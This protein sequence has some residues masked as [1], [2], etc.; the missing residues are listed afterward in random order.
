MR[1]A[2]NTIA[3]EEVA[4]VYSSEHEV[5]DEEA[6]VATTLVPRAGVHWDEASDLEGEVTE[7]QFDMTEGE[8]NTELDGNLFEHIMSAAQDPSAFEMTV[9]FKYVCGPELSEQ[10]QQRSIEGKR[11]LA[12]ASKEICSLTGMGF[13]ASRPPLE[14]MQPTL[15]AAEALRKRQLDAIKDLEK[16]LQTGIKKVALVGQ[17]LAQHQAVLGFLKMKMSRQD[18]ET[19]EQMA[20]SVARSHSQGLNFARR[21]VVWERTRVQSK[22]IE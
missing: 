11:E 9:H 2:E 17:N 7:E 6:E 13:P 18:G 21:I 22:M 3:V 19:R 4:V 5:E 10:S 1:Y 8:D 12:A 15:S 20:L 14:S 16:K